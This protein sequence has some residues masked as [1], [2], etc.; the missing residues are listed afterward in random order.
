MLKGKQTFGPS[1]P[2]LQTQSSSATALNME[3]GS[4]Y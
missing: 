2:Q 1:A 3:T 4:G